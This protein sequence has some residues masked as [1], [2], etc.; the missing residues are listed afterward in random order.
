[1]KNSIIILI[2]GAAIIFFSCSE[3]QPTSPELNQNNQVENSLAKKSAAK[4]IGPMDLIFDVSQ[5]PYY[6]D[7]TVDFG[8]YGKHG[9]RFESLGGKDGGQAHHFVENFEIYKLGD[10]T[11]VYLKGP[12]AGVTT[13]ANSKFRMNGV[14]KEA[15]EPFEAWLDRSVHISGLIIWGPAGPPPVSGIGTVRIN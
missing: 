12:D 1:M 6:W 3:N 5:A 13:F 10:P 8:V 4:L 7:G 2:I 11:I 9:I 14:V 15:N